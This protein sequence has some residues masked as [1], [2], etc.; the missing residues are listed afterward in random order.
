MSDA[1]PAAEPEPEPAAEGGV[2]QVEASES[3]DGPWAPT[4]DALAHVAALDATRVAAQSQLTDVLTAL[5]RG[6]Q[7]L[8]RQQA[9]WR[10]EQAD[11]MAALR[12]E[13]GRFRE[14]A[15]AE[16]DSLRE[17]QGTLRS[18]VDEQ[19]GTLSSSMGDDLKAAVEAGSELNAIKT[20][21]IA[22]E[23]DAKGHAET[24]KKHM[25]QI[26][27]DK[28]AADVLAALDQDDFDIGDN[29][30]QNEEDIEG[31]DLYASVAARANSIASSTKKL[32]AGAMGAPTTPEAMMQYAFAKWRNATEELLAEKGDQEKVAALAEAKRLA[33]E[34]ARAAKEQGEAM[35]QASVTRK[36][37]DKLMFAKLEKRISDLAEAAATNDMLAKLQEECSTLQAGL[38]EADARAA[39]ASERADL[40]EQAVS[41]L[42]QRVKELQTAVAPLGTLPPAVASLSDS[43]DAK[44]PMDSFEALEREVEEL[45]KSASGLPDDVVKE[46]S[47]INDMRSELGSHARSLASLFKE[48]ATEADLL[49]VKGETRSLDERLSEELERR[50]R[51]LQEAMDKGRADYEAGLR[52]L[53]SQM[54]DKPDSDWLKEFE[55]QIRDEVGQLRESG[56]TMVS[57]DDLEAQLRALRDK[58]AHLSGS[59]EGG[60]AVFATCL[61]CDRPLP[62]PAKW[63]E[64][65]LP[66]NTHGGLPRRRRPRT[67]EGRRR[68]PHREPTPHGFSRS[69]G[70][71]PVGGGGGIRPMSASTVLLDGSPV[72]SPYA[73]AVGAVGASLEPMGRREDNQPEV[74]MRAGFPMMNPKVRPMERSEDH[75]GLFGRNSGAMHSRSADPVM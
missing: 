54:S 73:Q 10:Q 23:N 6:E 74:V 52:N 15:T 1:E 26:E 24:L 32:L 49:G 58:M 70:G 63:K 33:G 4:E 17:E 40:A 61:A 60:S 37:Q 18:T 35:V 67:A 34:A 14:D 38:E 25:D 45:K 16:L 55:Q 5:V 11:G 44:T 22:L 46:L 64:T 57:A 28:A 41:P 43:L 39:N 31:S 3:A 48:K 19:I 8:R 72:P 36:L 59:G 75:S 9:A 20:R 29:N 13:L 69:G 21:L 66:P 53:S 68:T 51:A 71:V 65:E 2:E 42:Q 62:P 27:A 7:E 47:G 56:E 12:E 50:A 30:I